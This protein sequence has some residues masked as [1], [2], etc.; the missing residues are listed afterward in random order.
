MKNYFSPNNW[1][2]D[3]WRWDD[4]CLCLS[5][6]YSHTPPWPC[7]GLTPAAF[8][9]SPVFAFYRCKFTLTTKACHTDPDTM[10]L[11]TC[12]WSRTRKTRVT[13]THQKVEQHFFRSLQWKRH[14]HNVRKTFHLSAPNQSLR[15]H[16]WWSADYPANSQKNLVH[17][18]QA[19]LLSSACGSEKKYIQ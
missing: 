8:L 9:P 6:A 13:Q 12:G 1:H 15:I 19:S 4:V 17:S 16:Q 10:F 11:S 18:R 7:P 2:I 14:E 5:K 3:W